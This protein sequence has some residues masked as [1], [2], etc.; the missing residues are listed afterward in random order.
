MGPIDAFEAIVAAGAH[1]R[2]AP[3]VLAMRCAFEQR[4]GAF[5]PEDSWF[6]ARSRAFWDDAVASQRFGSVVEAE[7]APEA[8]SWLSPLE[9]AH[10]G[11]FQAE[12]ANEGVWLLRDL[13]GGAEFLIHLADVGLRDALTATQS[14]FDARVVGRPDGRPGAEGAETA[15]LPGAVFHPEDAV[16]PL[17]AVLADAR[18]RKLSTSDVLDA[19]LRMEKSLRSLSRVKPSYAYRL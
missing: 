11:L 16:A 7:L 3:H 4:T 18:Q 13:W 15:V 6:E 12:R 1:P 5:G 9:S 19:L 14:P 2:H 8:R 17:L 10:R